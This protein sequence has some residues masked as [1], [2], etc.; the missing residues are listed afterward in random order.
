MK[1]SSAL[2]DAGVSLYTLENVP[3]HGLLMGVEI[4]R[5]DA[6]TYEKIQKAPSKYLVSPMEDEGFNNFIKYEVGT[7]EGVLALIASALYEGSESQKHIFNALDEGYISA[8]SNVGE[9][10]A[11]YL[12]AWLKEAP[13]VWVLGAEWESHPHAKALAKWFA[14]IGSVIPMQIVIIGI[15]AQMAASKTPPQPDLEV[16][17]ESFDG[18]VVFTC[19]AQDT[20]EAQALIASSQFATAAKAKDGAQVRVQ[21]PWGDET[22]RL[23]VKDAMKGTIALLPF[24]TVPS[25]YRYAKSRIT[26]VG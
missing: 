8:E 25:G 26:P 1:L 14:L 22:R 17:L 18:T 6:K 11:A 16:E 15:E 3:A 19:N 21:T 24:A 9:E 20:W 4:S 2:L 12:A 23:H 5:D 7:E 10:E 13:S